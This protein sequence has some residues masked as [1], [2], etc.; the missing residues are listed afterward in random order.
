MKK[1]LLLI[2]FIVT[3]ITL[4]SC[5]GTDNS[6]ASKSSVTGSTSMSGSSNQELNDAVRF[7]NPDFNESASVDIMLWSGDGEYHEDL[8]HQDW[9]PEDIKGQNIAA[10]YATAKAFNKIFPNIKINLYSKIDDPNGEDTTWEQEIENFKLEHGKYPDMW[11]ST[12]VVGDVSSGL[13][14]D[15]SAFKDNYYYK[16]MMPSLLSSC[17]YFGFQAALPQYS[18]PWGVYVNKEL[19]NENNITVP[20]PDWSISEY[21]RFTGAAKPED[22]FY[23]SMDTSMRML[24]EAVVE[25]QLLNG[26]VKDGYIDITVP[27]FEQGVKKLQEQAKTSIY[28]LMGL[29][30]ISDEKW[31][32]LGGYS[33]SVFAKGNVLTLDGDPWMMGAGNTVGPNKIT[34]TDWDIYP[35]PAF[36]QNEDGENDNFIGTVLDP[37]CLYNYAGEDGQL[38]EIE[39]HKAKLA[40]N[41]AAF[42]LCDSRAWAA[43]VDQKFVVDADGNLKSSLTDSF[44]L[45]QGDLFDEQMNYWYQ[46]ASHAPFA[47]SKKFNGFA[48]VVEMYKNQKIYS[49]SDKTYPFTYV[50]E[51]GNKVD[52]LE[53]LS[54]YANPD[55][56]GNVSINDETWVNTYIAGIDIWN[57]K[58]NDRFKTS[59]DKL[60]ANIQKYYHWSEDQFK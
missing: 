2:L 14:L 18:L 38:N 34:S 42:W 54:Q 60:K 21:T 31:N 24:R 59:F 23:G 48:K 16:Q 33:F 25:K 53:Y 5:G 55:V 44:P 37:L 32:T 20:D 57:D 49:V 47:D 17:N 40:Y 15:L 39:R 27:E 26:S 3:G 1:I 30:E 50:D 51:S 10:V 56:V 12:N 28:S 58:M 4:A 41:F 43:R 36:T 8:G 9:Q 35:C 11:A 45:V 29:D 6:T 52:C 19:A 46:P 13:A 22:G 7:D